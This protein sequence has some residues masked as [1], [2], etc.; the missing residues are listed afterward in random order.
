[1]VLGLIL[2]VFF[3]RLSKVGEMG[4]DQGVD[5]LGG[6]INKRHSVGRVDLDQVHVT[7]VATTLDLQVSVQCVHPGK[8]V[9]AT[10]ACKGAHTAVESLVAILVVETGK[11]TLAVV[12]LVWSQ[13]GVGPDVRVKVVGSGEALGASFIVA[14]VDALGITAAS[15][16]GSSYRVCWTGGR[17]GTQV[18]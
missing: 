10:L 15:L 9:L 16:Y 11:L 1:M 8:M 12:A 2:W 18:C 6:Q 13:V 3:V 5:L 14:L 17:Q 7:Q 4:E